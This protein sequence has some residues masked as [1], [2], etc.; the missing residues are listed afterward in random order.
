MRPS[1]LVDPFLGNTTTDLPVDDG[2]AMAW[3][4][5]KAETGNTHPGACRPF[6][7]VSACAYSGGYVSGY[8]SNR[9]STKGR[10]RPLFEGKNATGF[11]HFHPSGT[12][13]IGAYANYLRVWPGFAGR[14]TRWPLGEEEAHPGYY[15]CTLGEG[16]VRA[17]LAVSPHCALHRYRSRGSLGAV[18]V[19]LS[20]IGL[21][22][23]VHAELGDQERSYVSRGS[24]RIDAGRVVGS[25][26]AQGISL[27]FAVVVRNASEVHA[28]RRAG[29]VVAGTH[30]A[31][32]FSD[33]QG[34]FPYGAEFGLPEG[35]T[36]A[37]VEVAFSFRSLER[38]LRH[39]DE[40]AGRSLEEIAAE[41]EREWDAMLSRISAR[42]PR[43]M[44]TR[45]YSALY[46]SL[47]KPIDCQDENPYFDID[48]PCMV[49]LATLW[50]QAKALM[51]LLNSL[52]PAVGAKVVATLAMVGERTGRLPNGL[53]LQRELDRFPEASGMA[54]LVAADAFFR[55]VSLPDWRSV[56][57]T[58]EDAFRAS[59]ARFLRT[60]AADPPSIVLNLSQAASALVRM[61]R[62][63]GPEDR[64]FA[65]AAGAFKG[66]FSRGL[67]P[68]RSG[69]YEGSNWNYSF[70]LLADQEG[71]LEL[72]RDRHEALERVD[73]FFGYY[74]SVEEGAR[75]EPLPFSEPRRRAEH[76]VV[77][78]R[79]E[80]L[81]NEPDMDSPWIYHYLGRPDRTCEVVKSVLHHRFGLG[82]G[83]LPGNDDSGGTSAWYV[84][85]A[86]GL[87][88][89]AGVPIYLL[90]LPELEESVLELPGG[91]LRIIV[92]EYSREDIYVA[93]ASLRGKRLDRAWLEHDELAAG[94][95]L[96]FV[97]SK[98]PSSWGASWPPP[99]FPVG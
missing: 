8:G 89:V 88:P 22:P 68:E 38:A 78:E 33:L 44:L 26:V 17:E 67:L 48:G 24:Y 23:R 75:Q 16:D 52:Y 74:D 4:W 35:Q 90:T 1:E 42:G 51:P 11:T 62:A 83:G 95:E 14:G 86:M 99:S 61:R 79:F 29:E 43:E 25:I 15:A 12:G 69:Y 18:S 54:Y 28:W 65:E 80:G 64:E 34:A 27:H 81:N 70:P 94:G 19:E 55:G 47:I 91:R 87:F 49:D 32:D 93:S 36:E 82:P 73:R 58:M 85:A 72:F 30:H 77:L 46:H 10:P 41:A 84:W 57:K 37:V 66:I 40:L 60:G 71:R 3:S 50:D 76:G 96:R 45:F 5:P 20:S 13:T 63:L 39:L 92:E 59:Q 56:L 21:D 31:Y 98:R 9:V 7:M 2:I 53:T 97:G 6:G